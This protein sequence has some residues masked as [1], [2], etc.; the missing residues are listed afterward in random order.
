MGEWSKGT[1]GKVAQR[2]TVDR[3]PKTRDQRPEKSS[4]TQ[5]S[6]AIPT[7]TGRQTRRSR[8]RVAYNAG[9][10]RDARVEAGEDQQVKGIAGRMNKD[11]VV[12]FPILGKMGIQVQAGRASVANGPEAGLSAARGAPRGLFR[13]LLQ[14]STSVPVTPSVAGA[15]AGQLGGWAAR[16]PVVPVGRGGRPVLKRS[17]LCD[18]AV[19]LLQWASEPG[20][21][22]HHFTASSRW[23]QIRTCRRGVA[24]WQPQILSSIESRRLC[25]IGSRSGND[26]CCQETASRTLPERSQRPCSVSTVPPVVRSH[27]PGPAARLPRCRW[28]MP[29]VD[30]V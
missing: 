9:C 22:T 4:T 25:S 20:P 1:H 14:H 21:W 16:A 10:P 26:C 15:A 29:C 24:I 18:H 6:R 30:V 2:W 13:C 12:F 27:T 11:R 19:H 23:K 5:G 7:K 3:G 8:I 28:P 17:A